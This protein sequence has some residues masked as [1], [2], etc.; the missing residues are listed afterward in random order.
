[1]RVDMKRVGIRLVTE[2]MEDVGKNVDII[3]D[4]G[5]PVGVDDIGIEVIICDGV[6]WCDIGNNCV[7]DDSADYSAQNKNEC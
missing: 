2:E 7:D 1:M 4:I 3:N 6:M 5:V